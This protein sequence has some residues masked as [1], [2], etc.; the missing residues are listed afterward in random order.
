MHTSGT[1]MLL[2]ITLTVRFEEEKWYHWSSRTHL[3]LTD[4]SAD[5]TPQLAKLLLTV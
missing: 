4:A 2:Y 5:C 1:E 3:I